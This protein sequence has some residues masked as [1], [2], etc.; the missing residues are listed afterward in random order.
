MIFIIENDY[1]IRDRER[2]RFFK[3][4]LNTCGS[5]SRYAIE[6]IKDYPVTAIYIPNID[7]VP[8]PIEFCRRVKQTY[9]TI[10]LI[11]TVP[12][13]DRIDL[14]TLYRVTDNMPKRGIAAVRLA[15]IVCELSRLYTGR[16]Q[17]ECKVNG[18]LKLT[19]YAHVATVHQRLLSFNTQALSV[20][21]HLAEA[22]PRYVPTEELAICTGVHH[23]KRSPESVRFQIFKI[24]AKA[25]A[26]TGFPVIAYK[27]GAGYTVCHR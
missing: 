17:I 14:D 21:R 6:K 4:P 2:R 15:E 18:D 11:V 7:T 23:G 10:P 20:L 27:R 13:G 16:D 1:K 24:N 19:I 12:A 26:R 8:N 5:A 3:F 22:Y 9:P 25:K